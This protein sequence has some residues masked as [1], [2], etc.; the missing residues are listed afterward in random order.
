MIP[1]N[2]DLH[3]LDYLEYH[4]FNRLEIYYLNYTSYM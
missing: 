3:T 2:T 4:A 1:E